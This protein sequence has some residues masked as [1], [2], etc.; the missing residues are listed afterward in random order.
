MG[1]VD[2]QLRAVADQVEEFIRVCQRLPEETLATDEWTVADVVR[3][4]TFWHREYAANVRS[5]ASGNGPVVLEGT[6][7]D[8][9]WS[10]VMS[11][12]DT[13]VPEMVR[14]L[15]RAEDELGSAIR[16]GRVHEVQYRKGA[17]PYTT[18]RFLSIIESHIRGHTRALRTLERRLS[19][20]ADG[21]NAR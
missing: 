13:A 1:D 3:H 11:L 19:R 2:D 4:V 17:T 14:M 10:G 7:A 20:Q 15:R 16:T 12:R 8:L 18:A 5:V 9:N 21:T 6:Y